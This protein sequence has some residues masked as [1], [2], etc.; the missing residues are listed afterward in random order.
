VA[1]GTGLSVEDDRLW[2]RYDRR[3][4]SRL[5]FEPEGLVV[6]AGTEQLLAWDDNSAVTSV[7]IG[8]SCTGIPGGRHSRAAVVVRRHERPS[9]TRARAGGESWQVPSPWFA[10]RFV[11]PEIEALVAYSAATPDAR[12]GLACRTKL[13]RLLAAIEQGPTCERRPPGVRARGHEH[14]IDLAIERAID[15][16]GVRRFGGRP[17]RGEARPRAVDLLEPVLEALPAPVRRQVAAPTIEARLRRFL[18]VRPWPF[19]LLQ[20][21]AT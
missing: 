12:A 7:G 18:D 21:D 16:A 20:G 15:R 4:G 2:V 8:W 17:V 13:E 10:W 19:D 5:R 6:S 1:R 3:N 11:W 14:D 9:R